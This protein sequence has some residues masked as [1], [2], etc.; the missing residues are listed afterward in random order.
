MNRIDRI[1][2]ILIQLQSKKVIKAQDIGSR[3]NISLRTVYRDM[4][5]LEEAGVPIVGEAGVGYSL[6]D[7]YRL[8]PVMLTRDEATAFITAEK[9]IEK[10]TDA[11]TE[12]TF[13]SAMYK[14]KAVL[15]SAEK[16]Y[17]ET[18]TDNIEVVRSVAVPKTETSKNLLQTILPAISQ[19]NIL[20]LD[21]FANHRQEDTSRKVEPIGIFYLGNYWYMIAFCQLRNDYRHF[22]LDRIRK[23]MVTGQVFNKEHPPLKKFLEQMNREERLITIVIHIE[24]SSLKHLGDQKYY[25]G[26]VSQKDQGD[27]ME[28]TFLTSSIEG[29]ARWYMMFGDRA[30]VISPPELKKRLKELVGQ[31]S[32][33]L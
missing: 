13:K 5:T 19:K 31:I 7:G 33:N 17:L 32:G 20:C 18:I 11:Y 12:G 23:M 24:K 6:M 28:M 26:F 14:I 10:H 1:S 3:F 2:A 29:F 16:D 21:Y 4:R 22:R 25:N 9:F 30:I 27:K 8:P 15:R